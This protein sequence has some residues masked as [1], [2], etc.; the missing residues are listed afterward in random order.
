MIKSIKLTNFQRHK[1]SLFKFTP[2]V[3][4]ISGKTKAGKS[5]IVR[6]LRYV[7]EN[8]PITNKYERR[9][10]KG[11]VIDVEFDDGV[12]SRVKDKGN[13]YILNGKELNAVGTDVPEE[14][15]Q[16][17][18]FNDF[19]LQGQFDAVK[20]LT[21]SPGK[22]AKYINSITKQEIIEEVTKNI[23]T[24]VKNITDEKN[25]TERL[26]L[27]N[28]QKLTSLSELTKLKAK[29]DKIQNK[30]GEH[31]EAVKIYYALSVIVDNVSKIEKRINSFPDLNS[32]SKEVNKVIE[33][34]KEYQ[35]LK[36]WNESL[37]SLICG[38]SLAEGKISK[39]KN[40]DKLSAILKMAE[41]EKQELN[42]ITEVKR[43]IDIYI[44]GLESIQLKTE[45]LN[46]EIEEQQGLLSGIDICPLCG[47]K[48]EQ[49]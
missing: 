36:K 15:S 41:E 10:Q 11:F 26:L 34:H 25:T 13:K 20:F 3:N 29:K 21:D 17:F 37:L 7:S 48:W 1:D 35:G 27:E 16:F 43:K 47:N 40:I 4:I 19:S 5:S 45:E 32:L 24:E 23:N 31:T 46:K 44:K 9:G 39:L 30:I 14:V 6:A 12:V 28:E 22:V 42:K 2:G 38:L 49:K 8:R 18:G 33:A